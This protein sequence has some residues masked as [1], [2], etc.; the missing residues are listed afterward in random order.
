MV[1]L[2]PD[3]VL[4]GRTPQVIQK[5]QMLGLNEHEV[6]ALSIKDVHTVLHRLDGLLATQR[7]PGVIAAVEQKL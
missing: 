2:K 4:V 5:L 1:Q 7:A 3:L 6:D